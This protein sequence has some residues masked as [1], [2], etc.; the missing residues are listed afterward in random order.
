M[1]AQFEQEGKRCTIRELSKIKW[2][3]YEPQEKLRSSIHW[4]DL[5]KP[6][7]FKYLDK[8]SDLLD[9]A[10]YI[11][12]KEQFFLDIEETFFEICMNISYRAVILEIN[13][14]RRSFRLIGEDS[15]ER[16]NYF[17]SICGLQI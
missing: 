3:V 2:E 16:Y 1:Y 5:F 14:L 7:C 17:I 13:D 12:N 10:N 11:E 8:L 4:L 9:S 15:K 6:V